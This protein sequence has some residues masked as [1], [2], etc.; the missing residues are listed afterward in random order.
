MQEMIIKLLMQMVTWLD[1]I[2]MTLLKQ[3]GHCHRMKLQQKVYMNC[4]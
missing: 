1:T 2:Q 4:A 3:F